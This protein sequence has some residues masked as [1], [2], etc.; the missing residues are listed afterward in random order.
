MHA[1]AKPGRYTIYLIVRDNTN[2]ESK[3][4]KQIVDVGMRA[5]AGFI[6]D[7]KSLGAAHASPWLAYYLKD[8]KISQE[9]VTD[10]LWRCIAGAYVPGTYYRPVWADFQALHELHQLGEFVQKY[11]DSDVAKSDGYV[12]TGPYVEEVGQAFVE[13]QRIGKDLSHIK[14]PVLLY[15][16]DRDEKFQLAGVR[17]IVSTPDAATRF[18]VTSWPKIEA[19]AHYDDGSTLPAKTR[20]ES[21]A[22]NGS[23]KFAFWQPELYV[24]TIW[25]IEN[26]AGVFSPTFGEGK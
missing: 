8:G 24:L 23:A 13:R 7:P 11:K 21:P 20:D 18:G 15:R 12:E 9:E 25:L 16:K 26:P 19:T 22:T 17:F 1:Y 6:A 4:V 14:P 3:P 10:L 5:L 2:V